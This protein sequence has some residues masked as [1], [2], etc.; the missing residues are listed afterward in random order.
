VGSNQLS[1]LT[2]AVLKINPNQEMELLES[3]SA[4]AKAGAKV[5]EITPAGGIFTL[6]KHNDDVGSIFANIPLV[7]ANPKDFDALLLPAGPRRP[8]SPQ[9]EKEA[10]NFVREISKDEKPIAIIYRMPD[11]IA[12]FNQDMIDL[13]EK[14]M[15]HRRHVA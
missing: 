3:E 9:V 1:G 7:R 10:K 2:V 14:R 15:Q 11:D 4:L 8:Q 12:A 5:V 13:F 6:R